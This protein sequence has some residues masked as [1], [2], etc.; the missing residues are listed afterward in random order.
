MNYGTVDSSSRILISLAKVEAAFYQCFV[1]CSVYLNTTHIVC[2]C[3]LR[4]VGNSG[5]KSL[6]SVATLP[7][8]IHG[9]ANSSSTQHTRQLEY[10]LAILLLLQCCLKV[11]CSLSLAS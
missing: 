10:F 11:P 2:S 7:P 5:S 1:V 3:T 4:H 8:V 9:L 6:V